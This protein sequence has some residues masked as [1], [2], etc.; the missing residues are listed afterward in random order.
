MQNLSNGSW[1]KGWIAKIRTT[2]TQIIRK[3]FQLIPKN[4]FCKIKLQK[5]KKCCQLVV[6]KCHKF[7]QSVAIYRGTAPWCNFLSLISLLFHENPTFFPWSI[8]E[9][10]RWDFFFFNNSLTNF[11]TVSHKIDWKISRY[12]SVTDWLIITHYFLQ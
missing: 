10:H 11:S 3:I 1:R 5:N 9:N 7:R 2:I 12:V 4:K 8:D 6:L